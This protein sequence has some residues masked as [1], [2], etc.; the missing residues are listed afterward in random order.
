MGSEAGDLSRLQQWWQ[1]LLL[2][3]PILLGRCGETRL[4]QI[5]LLPPHYLKEGCLWYPDLS[6]DKNCTLAPFE[7]GAGWKAGAHWVIK[8]FYFIKVLYILGSLSSVLP[9]ESTNPVLF[10]ESDYFTYFGFKIGKSQDRIH[11]EILIPFKDLMGLQ[12]Y[13]CIYNLKTVPE[14]SPT[15]HKNFTSPNDTYMLSHG[16][17]PRS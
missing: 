15:K 12:C 8:G 10:T 4:G 11:Y 17:E 2:V 16:L 14:G 6:E 9:N 5:Y 13:S 1:K 7:N 3:G